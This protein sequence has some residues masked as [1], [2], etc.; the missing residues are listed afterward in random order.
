MTAVHTQ[1][2]TPERDTPPKVPDTEAPGAIIFS[3]SMSDPADPCDTGWLIS[4]MNITC[5]CTRGPTVCWLDSQTSTVSDHGAEMETVQDNGA[6]SGVTSGSREFEVLMEPL[7][8]F[9]F[10][11]L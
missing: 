6:T 7:K 10:L 5:G 2:L 11:E 9:R 1:S 4:W 3:L 8:G